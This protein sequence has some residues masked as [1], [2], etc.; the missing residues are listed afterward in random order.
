M[1][2][3]QKHD[4]VYEDETTKAKVELAKVETKTGEETEECIFKMRCKLFRFRDNQWKERGIGNCKLLR[5]KAEKKIRFVMRQEKTLKPVGNF[6]LSESPLCDLATMKNSA[7]KAWFWSCNDCSEEEAA[8]EKLAVRFQNVE[9]STLFK[10]A[11]NAAKEFNIKAKAG[12]EDLVWAE[13]IEDV[14]EVLEDDI[15]TNKTADADGEEN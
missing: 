3:E 12:D 5:N 9:N 15:D 14:E 1:V 8:I 13:A 6:L 10:D 4:V 11:F 7:D 2:E